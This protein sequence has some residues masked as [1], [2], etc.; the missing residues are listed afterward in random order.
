MLLILGC[1]SY[2]NIP[3]P[4]GMQKKVITWVPPSG[5]ETELTTKIYLSHD[6][7]NW[8]L[9]ATFERRA[10]STNWVDVEVDTCKSTYYIAKMTDDNRY[11]A[12]K[13]GCI[14]NT[15]NPINIDGMDC[16]NDF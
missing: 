14:G 9:K 13:A 7:S 16:N 5:W 3:N 2:T 1:E 10:L 11:C 15:C 6:A 4:C 8:E 12:L